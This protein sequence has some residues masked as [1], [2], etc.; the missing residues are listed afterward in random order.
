[1]IKSNKKSQRKCAFCVEKLNKNAIES[2]LSKP[3][4]VVGE[5]QYLQRKRVCVL[6]FIWLVFVPRPK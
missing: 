4:N 6:R 5:N 1:M 3:K 2:E